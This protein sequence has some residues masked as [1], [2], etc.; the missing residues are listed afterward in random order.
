MTETI[1]VTVQTP[2]LINLFSL[3]ILTVFLTDSQHKNRG[4]KSER[5]LYFRW[6]VIANILLLLTDGI[7]WLVQG[8]AAPG[9]RAAQIAVTT[10]YYALDPLPSYFFIR[11]T[12]VVLNVPLE[13]QNRSKYWYAVPVVLHLIIA[14]ASPFTHWFFRIDEA[15][16][17]HRGSLLPISFVLSFVLMIVAAGKVLVRFIKA[18][19]QSDDIARNVTEYRWLLIFVVI[20][21]IGGI[22][23]V[24]FNNVTYV[25]NATVI[26][27]LMLYINNQNMEITTDTLTGLYNRRQAFYYF[28]HLA[29][30]WAK[31]KMDGVVAVIVLDIN[32]F[33]SINDEYGHIMGDQ[34]IVAVSRSLEAGFAWDDFVCRFGGDE[35]LVITKHGHENEL[36]LA[37]DR[38]NGR[39]RKLYHKKHM[40]FLLSVSAGYAVLDKDNN[41]LDGLFQVADAMMFEQK[42]KLLRRSGDRQTSSADKW[43]IGFERKG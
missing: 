35:F 3:I 19:R 43:K 16:L 23:Q 2:V 42:S 40:P 11:F 28:E 21:M 32:R 6:I 15:N 25:W 24:F 36:Q 7:T 10:F 8:N 18:G 37:I 30:D 29:R 12:D 31:E 17:Y 22:T 26:A 1:A 39:L 34:A 38:V 13:R 33:K 27:L 41:T 9:M 20:P 14:A 4:I 5:Y